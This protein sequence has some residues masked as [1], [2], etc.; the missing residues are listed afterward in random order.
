MKNNDNDVPDYIRYIEIDPS[1][2]IQ[3]N[4]IENGEVVMIESDLEESSITQR[5]FIL[6][7]KA[8]GTFYIEDTLNFNRLKLQV[9]ELLN[10]YTKYKNDFKINQKLTDELESLSLKQ[11]EVKQPV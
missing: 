3:V 1:S 9:T 7:K 5:I 4:I 8:N 10:S 11:I 2:H 6:A